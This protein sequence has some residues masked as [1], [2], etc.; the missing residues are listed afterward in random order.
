L[1]TGHKTTVNAM[2][3]YADSSPDAFDDPK[4]ETIVEILHR[5]WGSAIGVVTT[6][7]VGDATP[8]A[9]TG[10]TRTRAAY[11][12][13]IDQQLRG[14]TNYT[15]TNFTGPDVLFGGGAEQF[16]PGSTSYQGKDYYAEFA[17]AGYTI[18]LNKTSLAQAPNDKKALGIFSVSNLPVWLDRNVY[19]DNL[20]GHS[21]SP[22]GDKSD[23]TD[24]P[25]LKEMTLK[26]IDVLH[27]RGGRK[28]FF[29]MSEGASIDKQMHALDYDRALG[30]LLELD[31]TIKATIAKLKELKIYKDT[32]IIVTA[33]HGHG[34]GKCYPKL[35]SLWIVLNEASRCFWVRRYKIFG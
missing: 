27:Q 21:N 13:L 20:K 9:L 18:S 6:A 24:L 8:M 28:G 2:G 1:Y 30:D 26:S 17:K 7:Y 23:A 12:A 35:G 34:F 3:V 31:D 5:V 10:H 15:W 16:I 4:V 22:T 19:T 33:D 14:V 11:G 29:L 25:G 32:L